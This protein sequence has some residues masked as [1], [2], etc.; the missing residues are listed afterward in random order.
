ML[1]HEPKSR[2]D[3]SAG[4][5]GVRQGILAAARQVIVH[6]GVP[7][8]TLEA[9]AAQAGI[10][11]GGLLYHFPTKEAMLQGLLMEYH[12]GFLQAC[13]GHFLLD[14]LPDRPGRIHRAWIRTSRVG[15][16]DDHEMDLRDIGAIVTNPALA[17]PLGHFWS[18]WDAFVRKDGLDEATALVIRTSL[19]GFKMMKTLG[20]PIGP[21]I[22]G[23][24]YARLETMATPDV[25]TN[26][27]DEQL[28]WDTCVCDAWKG[29]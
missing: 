10:S 23:L 1:A 3:R 19:T 27:Y 11:K 6:Q 24:L 4:S 29:K 12:C 18:S 17:E 14:P 25:G 9:V 26:I 2:S 22:H 20:S 13:R 28:A 7:K 21:E 15:L 5:G 8:L 16:P